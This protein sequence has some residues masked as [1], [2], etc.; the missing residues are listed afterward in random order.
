MNMLGTAQNVYAYLVTIDD[1]FPDKNIEKFSN[2]NREYWGHGINFE[3]GAVLISISVAKR[4]LR[5]STGDTSIKY[6]T[7]DECSEINKIMIPYFK[8]DEYFKG[9]V[10]GLTQM[11]SKL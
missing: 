4:Q 9:V 6:L 10:D 7:D 5:I 2:R 1:Y 8:K 3:K 11:K